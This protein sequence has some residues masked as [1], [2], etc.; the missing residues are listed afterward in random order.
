MVLTLSNF[1]GDFDEEGDVTCKQT[2]NIHDIFALLTASFWISATTF[3]NY[4]SK[5]EQFDG[6]WESLCSIHTSDTKTDTD[7]HKMGREP[8]GN[9]YWCL[10]L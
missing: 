4:S 9:L 6:Y 3:S 2:F 7:T 5:H 8:N 10:S 1:D